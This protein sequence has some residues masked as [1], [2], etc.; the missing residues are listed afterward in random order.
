M[1]N[2]QVSVIYDV[3]R[4][5]P[6]AIAVSDDSGIKI[7]ALTEYGSSLVSDINSISDYSQKVLPAGFSATKF[8][9]IDEKTF[10]TLSNIQFD[11]DVSKIAAR[12][13]EA[14]QRKFKFEERGNLGEKS[15]SFKRSHQK[16]FRS[17]RAPKLFTR[18]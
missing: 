16:F 11:D 13:L 1:E 10:N 9:A 6:H 17:S 2:R 14:P 4:G 3:L 8:N 12:R 5:T 15:N 18:T 7:K